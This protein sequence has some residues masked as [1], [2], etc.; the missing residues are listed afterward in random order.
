MKPIPAAPTSPLQTAEMS[1]LGHKQTSPRCPRHV[2]F[3]PNSRHSA[4][5]LKCPFCAKSGPHFRV[6]SS[7]GPDAR[8][9]AAMKR[10]NLLIGLL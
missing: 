10:L 9:V 3:T 2:R 4:D 8:H 1:G 5:E 7:A 6:T